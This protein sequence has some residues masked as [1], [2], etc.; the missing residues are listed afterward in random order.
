[1]GGY[2]A[3][4]SSGLLDAR[5]VIVFSPQYSV[6]PNLVPWENRWRETTKNC[7]H[8]MDSLTINTRSEIYLFYDPGTND[9]RH[10]ELIS[11]YG[12]CLHIPVPYSGHYSIAMLQQ[13]GL[14]D[15][16][17]RNIIYG[18]FDVSTLQKEIFAN[19]DKSAHFLLNKAKALPYSA[20][21]Q[22]LALLYKAAALCESEPEYELFLGKILVDYGLWNEAKEAY[23]RGWKK[24]P[25]SHLGLLS[26]LGFLNLCERY[27]E[28]LIIFDMIRA[29]APDFADAVGLKIEKF[30][31]YPFGRNRFLRGLRSVRGLFST[32]SIR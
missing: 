21:R 16:T 4:R 27:A 7:T 12:S 26:Y 22:R 23:H 5:K 2:A 19:S 18:D 13:I 25:D 11:Q 3:Y 32:I 28:G 9:A 10:A 31:Q 1:M 24:K 15:S 6:D 20:K 29:Q 30:D 14:L 8:F 17:I